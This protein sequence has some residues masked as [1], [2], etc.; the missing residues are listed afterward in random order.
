[1]QCFVCGKKI[2]EGYL[3]NEHIQELKK[4]LLNERNVIKNPDFKHH[5]LICGEYK[6]R[7]IIEYPSVGY[8]CD[9]DIETEA[10]RNSEN[11]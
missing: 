11:E 6:E 4:M 9:Q 8:F 7:V 10:R 5:C 1:M 2:E 3:C